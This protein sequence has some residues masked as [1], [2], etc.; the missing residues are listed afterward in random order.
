MGVFNTNFSTRRFSDSPKFRGDRAGGNCP[1]PSTPPLK[2]LPRPRRHCKRAT[3]VVCGWS[4]CC[5]TGAECCSD[6]DR[7]V[8]SSVLR[9]VSSCCSILSRL[10][11]MSTDVSAQ[12]SRAPSWQSFQHTMQHHHHHHRTSRSF[13]NASRNLSKCMQK[14]SL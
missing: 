5:A 4:S 11:A 3:D 6:A 7:N 14:R 12:S 10:G 1:C 9:I 8:M 2:G 13:S